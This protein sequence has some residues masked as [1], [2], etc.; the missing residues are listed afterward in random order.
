[1]P[2]FKAGGANCAIQSANNLA[3]KL[4]AVLTGTAGPS[5]LD[6]YH[7]ERHPIGRYSARQSLT[8]PSL[9][10]LRLED[11]GPGLPPEEEAPMF[12]L[13]IG[14][15]YRSAAVVT[16]QP[17]PADPDAVS[18]VPELRAQPGTRVPHVWLGTGGQ[19]V[20]TLDL[21][22]PGFTVFTGDGGAAWQ[23]A[24]SAASKQL[25][26]SLAVQRIVDDGWRRGTGLGPEGAV[27]IRP[28]DMVGWRADTLPVDPGR[29][30]LGV[31][32]AILARN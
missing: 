26:I 8:G 7:A 20:S 1:M 10:L 30:L 5:L 2:P 28:D 24:A 18:L 17:V 27:L 14:H 15:Q 21:L 12:N 25:G 23:A 13:L 32:S 22:G 11:T 16:G 9:H 31:L 19:Q 4:A 6:T 3:W 29:E